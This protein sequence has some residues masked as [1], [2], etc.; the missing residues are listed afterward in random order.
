[1]AN[2]ILALY[3]FA[4]E[5]YRFVNEPLIEARRA[6]FADPAGND[7]PRHTLSSATSDAVIRYRFRRGDFR[8]SV[9]CN[10]REQQRAVREKNGGYEVH[11]LAADGTL[12]R[13]DHYNADHQLQRVAYYT[14]NDLRGEVSLQPNGQLSISVLVTEENIF[15]QDVLEA[16][17]FIPYG[18]G[19]DYRQ[20]IRVLGVPP[21]IAYTSN[22]VV[23]YYNAENAESARKIAE[24]T[25]K[26]TAEEPKAEVRIE[27]TEAEE[28]PL[29]VEADLSIEKS[30]TDNNKRYYAGGKIQNGKAISCAPMPEDRVDTV[31]TA[32]ELYRELYETLPASDPNVLHT[33]DL[34]ADTVNWCLQYAANGNLD[35]AGEVVG[36]E[37]RGFGV[38]A[39]IAEYTAFV[40]NWLCDGRSG[41]AVTAQKD[42]V[43]QVQHIDSL[44]DGEVRGM[45]ADF[46]D[47]G[48]LCYGGTLLNGTR[49]GFGVARMS[50]DTYYAGQWT[51]AQPNGQGVLLRTSGELLYQGAW[52]SGQRSGNGTAYYNGT[53]QYVGLWAADCYEGEGT[54]T[55]PNGGRLTALFRQGVPSGDVHEYNEAGREIYVGAWCNGARNGVGSLTCEDGT[56]LKGTFENGVLTGTVQEYTADGMLLYRGTYENGQRSGNGVLYCGESM[57][58]EGQFVNGERNGRGKCYENGEL[59]YAGELYNGA[60]C[61]IGASLQKGQPEYFGEWAEGMPNGCGVWYQNGEPQ[62]VGGFVNGKRNGRV[63]QY[64]NGQLLRELICRNG[65]DEYMVEYE[66]GH[67]VYAG[68]V[69]DGKRSGL[70]RLLNEYCECEQQGV[71]KEGVLVRAAQVIP[72]RSEALPCPQKL[73]GTPYG[74]LA[75]AETCYVLGLPWEGGIYSGCTQAQK[76]NG[77]GTLAY[78]DHIY[79][80][81][82]ADGHPCGE[83]RLYLSN[84]ETVVGVF[85]DAP[86]TETVCCGSVCY[87]VRRYKM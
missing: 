44:T 72:R 43:M 22:G 25:A 20:Y 18:A 45:A 12:F 66:N 36:D 65:T 57:V 86:A 71:F 21:V 73:H 7:G 59:V 39:N 9:R 6:Y 24:C 14:G 1:M 61:G 50:T 5:D 28:V 68:A 85:G 42:G 38:S 77:L 70:G 35:Y 31:P 82:F 34:C 33:V 40:G 2:P 55:L 17:P 27:T 4:M 11:V 16:C 87:M 80:G 8:W 46:D 29:D 37:R 3:T 23:C 32:G 63:N 53:V 30:G 48:M 13:V 49:N 69:F 64:A 15:Q 78:A 67:P 19:E 74:E 83:G 47:N 10:G 26:S 60:R 54:L 79:S 52:Q 58:Y 56:V 62:Y 41:L 75:E 76:P 81:A 84:G 51:D